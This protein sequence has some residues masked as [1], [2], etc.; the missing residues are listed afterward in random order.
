MSAKQEIIVF[1]KQLPVPLE[2]TDEYGYKKL[3]RELN[4]W[5]RCPKDNSFLVWKD[6]KQ[7]TMVCPNCGLEKPASPAPTWP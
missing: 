6:E 2:E 7:E 1:V 4:K 5:A 3:F